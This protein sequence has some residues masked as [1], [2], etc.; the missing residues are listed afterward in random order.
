M[1]TSASNSL[2]QSD[3]LSIFGL[4]DLAF[5]FK[6]MRR[7][8]LCKREDLFVK[9]DVDELLQLMLRFSVLPRHSSSSSF[10]FFLWYKG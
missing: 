4:S 5:A 6:A 3:R 8:V 1:A 7:L 10:F 9:F 2:I